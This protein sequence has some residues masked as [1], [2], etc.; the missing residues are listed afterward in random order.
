MQRLLQQLK[1]LAR[2]GFALSAVLRTFTSLLNYYGGTFQPQGVP[3]YNFS[4]TSQLSS[5]FNTEKQNIFYCKVLFW[6]KQR[7]K[8]TQTKQTKK[9]PNT[10]GMVTYRNHRTHLPVS[11]I[12]KRVQHLTTD[13]LL[14]LLKPNTT[15]ITL[16]VIPSIYFCRNQII[17]K[18]HN[19]TSCYR[20]FSLTKHNFSTISHQQQICVFTSKPQEPQH[21]TYKN[22][23]TLGGYQLFHSCC[24]D[25]FA[26]KMLPKQFILH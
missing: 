5:L 25:V 8:K 9:K 4:L 26:R 22:L 7:N 15:K 18:K 21:C 16:K 11:Y 10:I 6:K 1:A 17:Y 3:I 2:R 24:D 20:K 23:Q 19:N 12:I 13:Q 14:L